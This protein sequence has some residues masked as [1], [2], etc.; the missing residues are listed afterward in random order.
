MPSITL[1]KIGTHRNSGKSKST[2]IIKTLDRGRKFKKI[3]CWLFVD[4][5]QSN[6]KKI[7]LS[8]LCFGK[9]NISIF[10]FI[11]RIIKSD[12]QEW[13]F[14]IREYNRNLRVF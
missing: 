6:Q 9:P 11:S 8:F 14:D 5:M 3:F 13:N 2:G 10:G 12:Y 1:N 4:K 7:F